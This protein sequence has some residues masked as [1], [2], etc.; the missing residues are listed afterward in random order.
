[1]PTI[2]HCQRKHRLLMAETDQPFCTH[3]CRL[4]MLMLN[5]QHE[6]YYT[7]IIIIIADMQHKE[8][9]M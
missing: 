8:C 5:S 6:L 9:Q 7:I 4:T 3:V 1:M 2:C